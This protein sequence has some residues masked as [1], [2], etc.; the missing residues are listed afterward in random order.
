MAGNNAA[1]NESSVMINIR[2][3]DRFKEFGGIINGVQCGAMVKEL[4]E[5][6]W[7]LGLPCFEDLGVDL[8]ELLD[9][10]ASPQESDGVVL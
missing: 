1:T 6:V 2:G 8:V 5:K 10:F 7:V 3:L 4:E 9:G